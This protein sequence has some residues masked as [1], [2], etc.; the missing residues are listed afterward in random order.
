VSAKSSLTF[1]RIRED[2][3]PGRNNQNCLNTPKIRH[4]VRELLVELFASIL[5]VPVVGIIVF[6][7]FAML[8]SKYAE[9]KFQELDQKIE[10]I[11]QEWDR[12]LEGTSQGLDQKLQEKVKNAG[13]RLNKNVNGNE[14]D[15]KA[16]V[17]QEEPRG[18]STQRFA[19][20]FQEENKRFSGKDTNLATQRQVQDV[21][22]GVAETCPKPPVFDATETEF[23]RALR[24]LSSASKRLSAVPRVFT[25][26]IYKLLRTYSDTVTDTIYVD[27]SPTTSDY[28]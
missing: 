6:L 10:G 14:S 23:G 27:S 2:T 22:R 3:R 25:P 1:K 9:E 5:A 8:W 19:E 21:H 16:Y 24:D 28:D 20:L 13:R 4:V 18:R 15:A 17:V 11:F 7:C 12:K 26:G